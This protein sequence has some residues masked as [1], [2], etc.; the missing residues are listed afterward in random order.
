M[1]TRKPL[2]TPVLEAALNLWEQTEGQHLIPITG[3]SMLPFI[4]DGDRLLVAHGT[5]GARRGDVVVFRRKGK[6]IAHRVLYICDGDG[7]PAFITKGDGVS[8][9]DP[10]VTAD[11]MVG[12]VL[13]VKRGERYMSLDTAA[14]RTLGWLIALGTP[15]WAKLYS[16][17]RT[18]KQRLLGPRPNRLTTLMRRGAMASS[19]LA[20]KVLQAIACRW[21]DSALS[22]AKE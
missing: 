4:Q 5:I 19:S 7:G 3:C 1:T 20:L 18:L 8:D 11:E 14:W 6:L 21:K 12:R 10:A 13:A 15:A 17:G 16:W 22:S 2:P 9:L